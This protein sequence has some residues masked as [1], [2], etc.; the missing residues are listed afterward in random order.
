LTLLLNGDNETRLFTAASEAFVVALATP[1][2]VAV[3]N[4]V[5]SSLD[6]TRRQTSVVIVIVATGETLRITW[7]PTAIVSALGRTGATRCH[8]QSHKRH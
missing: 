4:L 1:R 5:Q 7:T 3:S 8:C 2:T 6:V